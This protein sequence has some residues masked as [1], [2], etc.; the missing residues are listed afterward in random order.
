MA[1]NETVV[2]ECQRTVLVVTRAP[3]KLICDTAGQLHMRRSIP[4]FG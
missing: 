2:G 1:P 4:V 3:V